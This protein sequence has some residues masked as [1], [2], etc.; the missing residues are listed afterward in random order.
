MVH[1]LEEIRRL[2]KPDGYLID[3]HP[4]R[5]VPLIKI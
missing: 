1:A 5:K 3:S 4:I 2:L